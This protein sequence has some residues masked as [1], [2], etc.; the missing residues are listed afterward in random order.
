M[1]LG[2]S[3][4]ARLGRLGPALS[5]DVV[6]ERDL[7]TKVP[8]GAVLLADHWFSPSTLSSAPVVLLRSPYGRRQL[9]VLG[10]LFSERG[11]QVI[12]QSC[13][14]TFGSGGPTFDPFHHERADGLATLRWISEQPWFTGSVATFGPS[15]LGLAQWAVADDPPSFLKA[16]AL[17]VTTARVRDIV[18]PGGSFALETGATWVQQLHLQERNPNTVILAMLLGRRRLR[19]AYTMLPL[20]EADTGVLGKK[21]AFYQDWLAHATPGDPW[22]DDLDWSRDVARM[23]PT[24]M[25]AGWHD[26]FLPG[27]LEDYR[28]LRDAGREVRLLIGP[29]THAS[30]R[31]GAAGLRD[32]LDWFD[33]HLGERPSRRGSM[34]RFWVGGSRRWVDVDDWPPPHSVARWNFQPAGGLSP[35]PADAGAP[36]RFRFDPAHPAPGLGGPSL[37]M[38]RAGR[39]NQ[40]R[41]E[42]RSDVLAYTSDVLSSDLTIAGP[43]TAEVW[44]RCSISCHDVFVRLCDVHPSGRSYNVCDGIIRLDPSNTEAAG[45]GSSRVRVPMWPAALRFRRGHRIRVQV[46]S[47]AHPL[48][49]RNPGS[50]EPLGSASTLTPGTLEVF[51]DPEHPSGIDL[52][53]TGI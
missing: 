14:G 15:Y 24:T 16:M 6:V 4:M 34:V 23:P 3:V 18:Y 49:A 1:S 42:S 47:A 35:T 38:V 2:S 45:D 20:S 40:R 9:G 17:Q 43:V 8:D 52:P 33:Q 51:H 7:E 25:L 28:R 22:W 10:R 50:G 13:R 36:D 30:P 27:Q 53:V 44:V 46:S 39:R 48:Y 19:G 26:P 11:Y 21:V 31:A 37:D 5:N 12:I 29:W 32:A 41:R